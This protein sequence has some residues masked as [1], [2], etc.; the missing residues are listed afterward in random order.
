MVPLTLN[1]PQGRITQLG[2]IVR[3]L[4]RL[5]FEIPADVEAEL[6]IAQTQDTAARSATAALQIARD[7]LHSVP[8]SEFDSALEEFDRASIQAFATQNGDAGFI[9]GVTAARLES[10]IS[11][12]YGEWIERTVKEY[13]SVVESKDL[14]NH[15]RNLP[16]LTNAYL[17]VLDLSDTQTAAISAWKTAVPELS[18]YWSVYVRL[19]ELNGHERIGPQPVDASGTNMWFACILGEANWAQAQNAAV[20]MASIAGGTKA[21]TDIRTLTPHIIPSIVGYDLNLTT[22]EKAKSRRM[23]IQPGSTAGFTP[24]QHAMSSY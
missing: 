2:G 15:G 6:E 21:S 8:A 23:R 13:N 7:N 3:S 9:S 10:A 14:N 19:A 24:V 1:S 17:R 4:R 11:R 20:V 18:K 5:D 12:H 22:P 16:D